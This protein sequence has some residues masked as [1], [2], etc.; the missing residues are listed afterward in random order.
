MEFSFKHK[1][2]DTNVSIIV[3]GGRKITD[4]PTW[5]SD[6]NFENGKYFLFDEEKGNIISKEYDCIYDSGKENFFHVN[7]G[8]VHNLLGQI[9][10]GGKW[11][12]IDILGNEICPLK[13]EYL[14]PTNDGWCYIVDS[15]LVD[16]GNKEYP[17]GRCYGG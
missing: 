9:I 16:K 13:Y 15:P 6:L 3:V 12:I 5:N 14:I 10:G 7:I 17:P 1:I 11:G 8:G 4:F 2:R